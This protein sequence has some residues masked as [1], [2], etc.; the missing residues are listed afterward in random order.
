MSNV[1]N[2]KNETNE[3]IGRMQE[4]WIVNSLKMNVE[5]STSN[6]QR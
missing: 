3:A 4:H 2:K 5:H 1:R 6:I